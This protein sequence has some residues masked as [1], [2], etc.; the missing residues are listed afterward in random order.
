MI[1]LKIVEV[2]IFIHL[3]KDV[4]MIIN[5]VFME[6]IGEVFPSITVGYMK[7]KAQFYGLSTKVK[8]A[9]ENCFKFSEVVKLTN[10]LIQIYKT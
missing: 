5:F 8:N 10:K 3:N 7:D 9:R 1:L 2:T 6:K 4:Y